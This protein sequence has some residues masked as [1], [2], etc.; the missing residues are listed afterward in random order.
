MDLLEKFGA[1]VVK[2]DDRLSEIDRDFCERH[3]AAYESAR[4]CFQE[5]T[6]IWSDIT[7]AQEKQLGALERPL[8]RYLS[9]GDDLKISADGIREHIKSLHKK[10]IKNIVHYFNLKYSISISA[11]TV[12]E[13]LLP[14]E[15]ENNWETPEEELD[16]YEEQMQTLVIR[17]EDV[18]EQIFAQLEGRGFADQ[19]FYELRRKCHAAAWSSHNRTKQFEVKKDTVRF[20][21]SACT[22]DSSYSAERWELREKMKDVMRGLAHFES[23]QFSYCPPGFHDLMQQT[24]MTVNPIEFTNCERVRQLRM[25]KSGRV[26]IK[27][28]SVQYANEF[29]SIYLGT[30]Y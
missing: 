26:D 28:T 23:V 19:A 1:V 24:R 5:L 9:H 2:Q 11:F 21:G 25:F 29:V 14:Q 13:H 17:Q 30:V 8:Y 12:L 10:L 20:T 27:F 6:Y 16:A 15:P 7:S 3:Q 4:A 18:L 22:C